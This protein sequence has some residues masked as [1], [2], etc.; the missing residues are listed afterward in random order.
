VVPLHCHRGHRQM[1]AGSSRRSSRIGGGCNS[2]RDHRGWKLPFVIVVFRPTFC[3]PVVFTTFHS[4][5]LRPVQHSVRSALFRSLASVP[6]FAPFRPLVSA[7]R[8]LVFVPNFAPFRPLVS[9]FRSLV[10]VPNLAPY[11]PLV[12]AFRSLVSVPPSRFRFPFA[13]VRSVRSFPL[14]VR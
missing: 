8:S 13:R 7:F 5:L 3:R 9:A 14:S 12:S 11:R 4:V 10:Y 2:L 6:N 1:V